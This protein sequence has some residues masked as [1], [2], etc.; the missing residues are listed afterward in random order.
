M[1]LLL[2][3]VPPS[4]IV[5]PNRELPNTLFPTSSNTLITP[6][7]HYNNSMNIEVDTLRG[8]SVSS[9][10]NVSRKT[11]A[12]SSVSSIPYVER[13]EAQSKDLS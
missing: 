13:M 4:C 5:A 12:H 1:S 10:V 7:A 8:R 3:L 11:L 9:S 2:S 6:I